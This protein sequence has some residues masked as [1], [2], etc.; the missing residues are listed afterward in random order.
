MKIKGKKILVLDDM[1]ERHEGFKKILGKDHFLVRAWTF[2]QAQDF[3]FNEKWDMVCL[4]H[5]LGDNPE[6]RPDVEYLPYQNHTYTGADLTFWL[7]KNPQF[8][9][10][11]VLIH[12]HNWSGAQTMLGHLNTLGGVI[13][14]V[15]E[16]K[17]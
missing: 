8:C 15:M 16:F 13:V 3:L 6:I 1:A 2:A 5:D 4:D 14:K 10:A 17:L 11:K 12:S 7:M 9:P